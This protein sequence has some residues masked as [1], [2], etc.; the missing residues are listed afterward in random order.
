MTNTL[1]KPEIISNIA[2]ATNES[3]ATINRVL[4]ALEETVTNS[5]CEG[6]DVKISGFLAFSTATRPARTTKNPRTGEDVNV[7]AR[8]ALRIR[9]LSRLKHTVR[10]S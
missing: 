9:P 2:D 4:S 7:P 8:R 6:R 1:N 3:K 10:S 5:L